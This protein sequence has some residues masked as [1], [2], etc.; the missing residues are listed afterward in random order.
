[1]STTYTVQE[2]QQKKNLPAHIQKIT[3]RKSKILA[4]LR[5]EQNLK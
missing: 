5:A 2:Y 1:M 4:L 3:L